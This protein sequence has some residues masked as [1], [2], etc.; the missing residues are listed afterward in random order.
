MWTLKSRSARRLTEEEIKE[1]GLPI[2]RILQVELALVFTDGTKDVAVST[3]VSTKDE[4]VSAIN[5]NLA[6][7]NEQEELETNI[8]AVEFVAPTPVAPTQAELDQAAWVKDWGTL[9]KI[10]PLID[11]GVLTG[12][13]AVI[14]NLRN[15]VKTNFKPAFLELI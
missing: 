15:R 14:T 8:E 12:T 2:G 9:Q 13:E 1:H 3:F 6:R 4:Y 7:L 11:A 10:Q 5:Q